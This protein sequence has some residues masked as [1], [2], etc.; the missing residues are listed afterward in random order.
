MFCLFLFFIDI[1]LIYNILSLN[2]VP[3]WH[4]YL[5]LFLLTTTQVGTVTTPSYKWKH[6][7]TERQR[8]LTK[9]TQLTMQQGW[10]SS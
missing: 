2:Q 4:L 10:D 3:E 1:T 5:T 7:G 6:A 9:V 8:N